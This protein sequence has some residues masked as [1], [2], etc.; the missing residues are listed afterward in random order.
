MPDLEH[1]LSAQN[2]LGEGPL[3][4]DEEASL[5]WVDLLRHEIHRYVPASG[6]HTA[7]RCGRQVTALAPRQKGGWIFA[8]SEGFG[9][10]AEPG[11]V[12]E[13]Q[14]VPEVAERP[15][16][17]FNDGRADALGRFWAGTMNHEEMSRT[18][19]CLY[20]IDPDREVHRMAA[21]FTVSNGLDWSPDGK[22][23]YFTD[24]L[25]GTIL[26]YDFDVESGN[27]SRPRIFIEVPRDVG[28]PDGLTVDSEGRIWSANWGGGSVRCYDPD[29]RMEKDIHLP[30]RHVTS[31]TF[32]GE[33]LDILYIT[34][35]RQGLSRTAL[36]DQPQAGDLFQVRTGTR[37]RL[38]NRYLG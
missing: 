29:G 24:S 12:V 34:T 36:R 5:Y 22:T 10:C 30:V 26:A 35:A 25:A 2:Q 14:D 37:G 15:E 38:A 19:G 28:F 27:I 17:R 1:V 31:C 11:G 18:D 33:N 20:R 21:G 3:W 16:I 9:F 6:T 7:V 4:Q 32:G 13:N 23:L 8:T